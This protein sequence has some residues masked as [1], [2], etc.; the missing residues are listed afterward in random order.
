VVSPASSEE[1]IPYYY[2]IEEKKS[3]R[4]ANVHN[5]M[6]KQIRWDMMEDASHRIPLQ[7]GSLLLP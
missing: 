3:L 1:E 4:Q 5:R 6:E 7:S 2:F